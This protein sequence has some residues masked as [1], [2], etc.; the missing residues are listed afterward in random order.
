LKEA[1][2]SKDNH[3]ILETFLSNVPCLHQ[4]KDVPLIYKALYENYKSRKQIY[5]FNQA[6]YDRLT[7]EQLSKLGIVMKAEVFETA[8]F[9]LALIKK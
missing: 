3:K 7:I 8:E 4:V 1:A 6:G 2:S 5:D 9:Q